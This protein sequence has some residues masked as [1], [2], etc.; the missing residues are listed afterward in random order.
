MAFL[1][2]TDIIVLLLSSDYLKGMRG[3]IHGFRPCPGYH[4]NIFNTYAEPSGQ[5]DPR[6]H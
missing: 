2:D 1:I 6:F 5:V 3:V 4:N